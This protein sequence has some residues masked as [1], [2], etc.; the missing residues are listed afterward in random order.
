MSLEEPV[1]LPS[2]ETVS[3]LNQLYRNVNEDTLKNLN[4]AK[5]KL[6]KEIK[7]LELQIKEHK[8]WIQTIEQS[9]KEW[10]AF[11]NHSPQG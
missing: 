5:D 7:R 10:T 1:I 9:I 6:N 11:L 3:N 8:A 4:I 2:S